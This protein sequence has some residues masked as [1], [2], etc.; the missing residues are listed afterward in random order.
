M[1]F[2]EDGRLYKTL[3][4]IGKYM[5]IDEKKIVEYLK[6]HLGESISPV[7]IVQKTGA[8]DEELDFTNLFEITD[9]VFR[10]GRK[11]G[12]WLYMAH[13]RGKAEGVPWNLDFIIKKAYR[14][15]KKENGA[16]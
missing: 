11:N 1:S 5:K 16:S 3:E 8:C 15:K 14:R 12:F 10:I 13:H 4:R 6:N 9:E 7:Q 2:P